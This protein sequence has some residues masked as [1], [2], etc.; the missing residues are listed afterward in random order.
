MHIFNLCLSLAQGVLVFRNESWRWAINRNLF[1]AYAFRSYYLPVYNN[2]HIE[3]KDWRQNFNYF[4][5]WVYYIC[6]RNYIFWVYLKFVFYIMNYIWIICVPF[7]YLSYY[8]MNLLINLHITFLQETQRLIQ[9]PV[10]GI[11]AVP[12]ESNARY[13]HVIVHGPKEVC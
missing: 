8:A 6:W 10:E 12:D 2:V 4:V 1:L 3:P 13:F 9:E 11:Q 5:C 7:D